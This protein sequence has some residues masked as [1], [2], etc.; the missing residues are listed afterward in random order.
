MRW[1][2]PTRG[3]LFPDAFL[4]LIE[5]RGFTTRLT[6]TVLAVA[7]AQAARGTSSCRSPST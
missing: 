6:D 5:Q 7:V 3:L 4:G 1:Q 2:H